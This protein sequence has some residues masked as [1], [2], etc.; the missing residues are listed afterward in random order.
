[1][2]VASANPG[3]LAEQVYSQ[4]PEL[5]RMA[6]IYGKNERQG[7]ALQTTDMRPILVDAAR[8]GSSR[9]ARRRGTYAV[10]TISLRTVQA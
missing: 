6:P 2:A 3:R 4:C 5:R 9:Q 10:L 7:K 8:A 1:M